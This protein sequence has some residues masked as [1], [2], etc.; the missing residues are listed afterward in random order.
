MK[1]PLWVKIT[2]TLL[3]AIILP[4]YWAEYG[5]VNFLWFSDI[6][7]IVMVPALWYENRVLASMMGLSVLLLELC[8]MVD[9]AAGGKL[10]T[11]ASYMFNSSI[12][13]HVRLLS[14]FHIPLPIVILYALHTLGYDKRA[15]LYQSIFMA[16]ILSITYIFADPNAENIN[17]VFGLGEKAQTAVHPLIY[18]GSLMVAIPLIIYLPTH[19]I[20]KKIFTGNSRGIQ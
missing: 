19:F 7:L 15:L 14:L 13:V 4:I 9:F 18:L 16:L 1:I 2:Y 11:L 20:L 6:A 5:P 10:I 17:W 12:P 3:V 8:W